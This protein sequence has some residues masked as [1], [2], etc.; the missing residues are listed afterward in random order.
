[1]NDIANFNN[2]LENSYTGLGEKIREAEN[3]LTDEQRIG[4]EAVLR[5]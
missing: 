3:A 1:M 4:I 5:F 2:Y